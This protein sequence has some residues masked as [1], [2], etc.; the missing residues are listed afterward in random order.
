MAAL[1]PWALISSD[2]DDAL[3][4]LA[5]AHA[6]IELFQATTRKAI[7]QVLRASGIEQHPHWPPTHRSTLPS[8]QHSSRDDKDALSRTTSPFRHACTCARQIIRYESRV[9]RR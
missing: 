5:N 6:D 3:L 8:A 9:S 2:D 7:D 1:S 4:D